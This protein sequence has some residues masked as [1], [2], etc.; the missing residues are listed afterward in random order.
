MTL[1]KTSNTQTPDLTEQSKR[2]NAQTGQYS[3]PARVAQV[4]TSQ[5]M[6]AKSPRSQSDQTHHQATP[7]DASVESSLELPHERDQATDMTADAPDPKIKQAAKDVAKGMSD[8]SK[9][10][11]LDATYRKLG[12]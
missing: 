8:T 3:E 12:N 6:P 5:G 2:S 11:E 1:S 7:K 10:P 4:G 9:A